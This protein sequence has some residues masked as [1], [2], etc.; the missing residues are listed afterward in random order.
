MDS[1]ETWFQ[2]Q[3]GARSARRAARA[4]ITPREITLLDHPIDSGAS[5]A[6]VTGPAFRYA[7]LTVASCIQV[8]IIGL[9]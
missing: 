8:A 1:M 6:A 4:A 7:V 9:R 5:N 2:P 3:R